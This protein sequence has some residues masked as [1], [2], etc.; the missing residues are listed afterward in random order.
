MKV[1]LLLGILLSIVG[2]VL[3]A[4]EADAGLLIFRPVPSNSYCNAFD[5]KWVQ[6]ESCDRGG[7]QVCDGQV[8]YC[9]GSYMTCLAGA[10]T[11]SA[12]LACAQRQDDCLRNATDSGSNCCPDSFHSTNCDVY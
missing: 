2:V 1:A 7:G 4:S 3:F 8:S 10:G 9:W 11:H 6:E 5:P 12:E